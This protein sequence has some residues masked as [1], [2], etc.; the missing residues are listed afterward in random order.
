MCESAATLNDQAV[1]LAHDGDYADALLCF[2]RAIAIESDN[3]LLWYNLGLTYR[4]NGELD[5]AHEALEKAHSID[6]GDEDT[7]E[8]L[9]AICISQGDM[10][11]AKQWCAEGMSID[12][13][14]P[15]LWNTM[16]V[17]LFNEGT[18]EDACAMFEQAVT[19]DP[20]YSEALFNL[21][22]TYDE[23]GNEVGAAECR[24]RLAS[25]DKQ[26][27]SKQTGTWS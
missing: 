25:L 21:G 6:E 14:N 8:A 22:D 5:E 24:R 17:I 18:Y 4:D 9:A 16:G 20:Y 26:K 11:E 12:E 10:D 3:A 7:L 2:S 13:A 27:N 19:L 15:H 23:M 1:R